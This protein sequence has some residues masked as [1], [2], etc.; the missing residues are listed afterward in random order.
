MPPSETVSMAWSSL[1]SPVGCLELQGSSCLHFPNTG[2]QSMGAP[3]STASPSPMK[4]SPQ[5]FVYSSFG[6]GS[7][8]V[9]GWPGA[10]T[11]G[12]QR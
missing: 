12:S 4:Q 2:L 7:V 3:C 6:T 5:P 11:L 9:P 10:P 1:I 8:T